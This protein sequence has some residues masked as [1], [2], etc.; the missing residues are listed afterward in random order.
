M[1]YSQSGVCLLTHLCSRCMV[2]G[3]R[4]IAVRRRTKT[5]IDQL[6]LSFMCSTPFNTPANTKII[7]CFQYFCNSFICKLDFLQFYY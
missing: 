1:V 6:G 2:H 4:E 7:D 5:V 3:M